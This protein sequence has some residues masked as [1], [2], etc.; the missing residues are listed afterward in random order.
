MVNG[1]PEEFQLFLA[2]FSV[3]APKFGRGRVFFDLARF[4]KYMQSRQGQG[5]RWKAKMMDQKMYF[6][7][8]KT[9]EG[10]QKTAQEAVQQW[11]VWEH[12]AD[13]SIVKDMKGEGGTLRIAVHTEDIVEGY[14]Y[15]EGGVA[16]EQTTKDKKNASAGDLAEWEQ[17]VAQGGQGI[18]SLTSGAFANVG[19]ALAQQLAASGKSFVNQD[20]SMGNLASDV[21]GG[22]ANLGDLLKG[23]GYTEALGKKG[24]GKGTQAREVGASAAA[25]AAAPP[26][27]SSA[28]SVSVAAG[29]GLA[30]P[31][32][33]TPKFSSPH[34]KSSEKKV[35]LPPY[36][37]KAKS[38]MRSKIETCKVDLARAVDSSGVILRDHDQLLQATRDGLTS[39]HEI[40]Q[41]RHEMLVNALSSTT[42]DMVQ[43]HSELPAEKKQL[44]DMCGEDMTQAAHLQQLFTE[45]E[46]SASKDIVDEA[47]DAIAHAISKLAEMSKLAKKAIA[48]YKVALRGIERAAAREETRQ[49]Q[50]QQKAA[51]A[52]NPS[53]QERGPRGGAR[54]GASVKEP[55]V[56]TT[57]FPDTVRF[58]QFDNVEQFV[59]A[60]AKNSISFEE[61][62]MVRDALDNTK[63]NQTTREQL[64]FFERDFPHSHVFK[65]PNPCGRAQASFKHEDAQLAEQLSGLFSA[66]PAEVPDSAD[67]ATAKKLTSIAFFGRGPKTQHIGTDFFSLGST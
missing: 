40:L 64:G 30:A 7:W 39:W 34:E 19:G 15:V 55:A 22:Q 5:M 49:V 4:K 47:K 23:F 51:T 41:V 44:I 35:D 1:R 17:Q 62:Y 3:E 63:L 54:A 25:A 38:A 58:Q 20:G 66:T 61:P 10:G 21:A 37:L 31:S 14:S 18:Q 65:G 24:K 32:P 52:A 48:D 45:L 53:G 27:D 11:S 6:G 42:V 33:V 28:S 2:R 12:T 8:A 50:Q 59:Q 57:P 29:S 60:R 56:F 9:C 43:W 16:L 26:T 67:E 36:K 13:R 46:A